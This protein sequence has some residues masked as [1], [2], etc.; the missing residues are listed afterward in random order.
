MRAEYN[1]YQQLWGIGC[2]RVPAGALPYPVSWRDIDVDSRWTQVILR[3]LGVGRGDFVHISHYYSELGQT[4]PYYEAARNIGA[5]FANGMPSLF[6]A[7]RLEMYLRRFQLAATIGVATDTLDGLQQG[8]HDIA[9][10][11]AKAG[12]I[13]ALPGGWERLRALG[14]K[15]WRLLPLGPIFAIEAPDGSGARFDN[16]EWRV[17]SSNGQLLV[18]AAPQRACDFRALETGVQGTVEKVNGEAGPELRVFVS[19]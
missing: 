7:Y 15:P 14:F 18:S 6:D 12:T 1:Q 11:Y 2:A 16:R 13:V 5:V 4:W 10:L 19:A 3:E 9:K 8:G 17:D